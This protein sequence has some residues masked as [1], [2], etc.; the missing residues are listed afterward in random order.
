MSQKEC[1]VIMPIS[2]QDGFEPEPPTG[3]SRILSRCTLSQ[4][5]PV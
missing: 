5:K 3:Q 2:D 4:Y 1:F